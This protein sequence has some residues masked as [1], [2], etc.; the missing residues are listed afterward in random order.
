VLTGVKAILDND[1]ET[2]TLLQEQLG[3]FEAHTAI[4]MMAGTIALFCRILHANP[5]DLLA[6]LREG[7]DERMSHETTD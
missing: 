5:D 1:A 6:V 2:V 4:S 7:V 3:G